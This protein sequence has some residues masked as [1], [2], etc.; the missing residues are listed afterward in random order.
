MTQASAAMPGTQVLTIDHLGGGGDGVAVVDG[1][2][3]F[4]AGALPGEVVAVREL[5]RNR[6]GVHAVVERIDQ[7]TAERQAPPCPHFADSRAPCGGC[8]LQHLAPSPYRD[9]KSE[10]IR[11]AL[12]H[13]G[14]DNAAGSAVAEPVVT[15]PR[16]RRRVGL[17][18]VGTYAGAVLGFQQRRSHRVVDLQDCVIAVPA[19]TA[20]LPA[21]RRALGDILR[22]GER[23]GVAVAALD[24]GLTLE[25]TGPT[26]FPGRRTQQRL[27][28]L[29]DELD[30][31]HVA[32]RQSAA[33]PFSELV[34]RRP[35]VHAFGGVDVTLPYGAF[36]Q[37]TA[38]GEAAVRAVV[39]DAVAHN[40]EAVIADLYAGCGSLT[41]P[42]ARQG[43]RVQAHETDRAAMRA[44]RRA[45][46]TNGLA[47]TGQ[48]RD[49]E[50]APLTPG[51]C[52]RCDCVVFDPPRSGARPTAEA[53]ARSAVPRVVA[54]S[55]HPGTFAR[56][57]RILVDG[58]YQ[59]D[60]IQPIDQ[61]LYSSHVEL[62]AVLTRRGAA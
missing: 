19:I 1:E 47:V 3:W 46:R 30:L 54:V 27:A 43:Y 26:R 11:T 36:L 55:C 42:L 48:R 25:L 20:A 21:L 35:A 38:A 13:R 37:A 8:A 14:L 57:V 5:R 52:N 23:A 4:I 61:F 2:R 59:I 6:D 44:L 60:S 32:W 24:S 50:R 16:S 28:A 34:T 15:P 10:L 17:S 49:L 22:A 12:R 18:A 9:F 39:L 29:A 56:D 41:L 62:A 53:L 31:V 58:G 40:S 45:A 33:R 51:E 7:P